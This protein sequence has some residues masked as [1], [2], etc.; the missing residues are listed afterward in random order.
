MLYEY[1]CQ[2]CE[3][4]VTILSSYANRDNVPP[5]DLDENGATLLH[6]D[7]PITDSPC[8][9]ALV[10]NE[11]SVNAKLASRWDFQRKG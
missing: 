5:H 10:R 7:K 3:K 11:I 1:V 9:G 2:K 4:T 6:N 8:G